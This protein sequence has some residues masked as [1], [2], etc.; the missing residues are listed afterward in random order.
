M[1]KINDYG[2]NC[3]AQFLKPAKVFFEIKSAHAEAE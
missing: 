1:V 2:N 3:F